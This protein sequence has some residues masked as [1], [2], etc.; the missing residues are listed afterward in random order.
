MYFKDIG[1]ETAEMLVDRKR[2]INQERN[3]KIRLNQSR[4]HNRKHIV[5]HLAKEDPCDV[6]AL[7]SNL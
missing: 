1:R 5:E 4:K 2:L 7:R 3:K 6:H